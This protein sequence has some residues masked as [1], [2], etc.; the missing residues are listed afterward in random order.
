MPLAERVRLD[1]RR[2][3]P[4]LLQ[5]PVAQELHKGQKKHEK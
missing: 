4:E 3:K 5:L 1:P 2:V